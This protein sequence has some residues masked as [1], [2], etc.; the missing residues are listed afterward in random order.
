M[1]SF[2][3]ESVS[4]VPAVTLTFW[5]IKIAATTLGETGGDAVSMS[6][7]L[8]YA[9]ASLIFIAI[10]LVAVF[11]QIIAKKRLKNMTLE[12]NEGCK[13]PGPVKI[14]ESLCRRLHRWGLVQ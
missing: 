12:H 5:L 3:K 11:A 14:G 9:V 13:A 1:N 10:F 8:G 7:D 4:K 2:I 6:M